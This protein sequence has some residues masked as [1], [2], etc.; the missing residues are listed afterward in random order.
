MEYQLEERE[1]MC[2]SASKLVKLKIYRYPSTDPQAGE[3]ADFQCNHSSDSCESRCTYR[4][5]MNDY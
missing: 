1:E 2:S 4:I 5:L 3:I